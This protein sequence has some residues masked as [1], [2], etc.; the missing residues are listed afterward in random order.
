MVESPRLWDRLGGWARRAVAAVLAAPGRAVPH[1]IGFVMDGNRRFAQAHCMRKIDGH[2]HGYRRLIDA[3]EWCLE[4]GVRCVS[5]YAFSIDN[6]R[7][8][9]EEVSMLM[10]LAE[11]KLAHMLEEFDVLVR[12]GVQVRVIGD[13][14]LA[15]VAVQVAASRIMDATAHH[16]R[17]VLNLCFSYTAS[18]ELHRAL[19]HLAAQPVSSSSDISSSHVSSSSSRSRGVSAA[20]LDAHL[21]TAGCPPVDLLVRTSGETRLSDF[22]LWQC[23]HALLVFTSVLWPEFG[24]LDL[25]AAVLEFQRHAP[26]LQRLREAAELQA[27]TVSCTVASGSVPGGAA[28]LLLQLQP[29]KWAARRWQD[30]PCSVASPASPSSRSD[31][32][33][34]EEEALDTTLRA[35][36]QHSEAAHV[37]LRQPELE[38]ELAQGCSLKQC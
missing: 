37:V 2:A 23:R 11:D 13:L 36:L 29:V 32:A 19:D 33:A 27:S 5:V 18:E 4:L 7:R 9:G 10:A 22:L 35:R 3:L 1:H 26:H 21:Y 16:T 34:S 6:Y 25:V 12:H 20:A 28:E 38:L 24:F 8:S 15:P 31:D 14:S 30:S 17:A